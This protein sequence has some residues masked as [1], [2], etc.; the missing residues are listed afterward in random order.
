EDEEIENQKLG[1]MP[2]KSRFTN[3]GSA[4][5]IEP[6]NEETGMLAEE[7]EEEE[8]NWL[9]KLKKLLGIYDEDDEDDDYY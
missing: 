9:I 3:D 2:R 5:F 1:Y 6:H 7:E 8:D 4:H